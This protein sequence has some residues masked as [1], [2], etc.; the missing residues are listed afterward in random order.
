M[1]DLTVSVEVAT[2]SGGIVEVLVVSVTADVEVVVVANV[3]VGV[4]AVV[5]VEGTVVISGVDAGV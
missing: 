4:V 5:G 1:V 3:V 2:V